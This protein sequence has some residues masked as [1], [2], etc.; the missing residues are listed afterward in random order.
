MLQQKKTG[1]RKI[2]LTGRGKIYLTGPFY[3]ESNAA[4]LVIPLTKFE[5][6]MSKL[7]EE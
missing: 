4:P 6:I 1:R 7:W 3:A 5:A 2:Y